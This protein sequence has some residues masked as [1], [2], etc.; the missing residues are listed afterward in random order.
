MNRK[1]F[2]L[3]EL[4]I[5]IVIIGLLAAVVIAA[6]NPVETRNRAVD[7]GKKSDASEIY[8]AIERYYATKGTYPWTTAPTNGTAIGNASGGIIDTLIT[9]NELKNEFSNR[10][11]LTTLLFYYNGVATGQ[12]GVRICYVPASKAFQD[13]AW[14]A[15]GSTYPATRGTPASGTMVCVP[16]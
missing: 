10:S 4:L 6:I 16:E 3:I 8:N 5:V 2:T 1:G 7:T 11:S 9:A 14:Y 12:G 15:S 13:V